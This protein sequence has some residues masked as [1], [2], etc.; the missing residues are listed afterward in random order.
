MYRAA[1]LKPRAVTALD[2]YIANG[3]FPG[4]A[5]AA[6]RSAGKLYLAHAAHS[7]VCA[8]LVSTDFVSE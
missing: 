3:A 4:Q 7:M 8:E 5:L 6:G 1:T 2:L